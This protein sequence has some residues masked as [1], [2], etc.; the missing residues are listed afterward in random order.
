MRV[1]DYSD[2]V[3]QMCNHFYFALQCYISAEKTG[4]ETSYLTQKNEADRIDLE[5]K[6]KMFGIGV[7]CLRYEAGKN[8]KIIQ[9]PPSEGLA[10][11]K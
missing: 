4:E 5:T 10:R 6:F 7:D 9:N 11:Y 8:D 1:L 3:C 2:I